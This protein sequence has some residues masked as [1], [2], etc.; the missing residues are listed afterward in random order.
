[1]FN[2]YLLF[3]K[4]CC[5]LSVALICSHCIVVMQW[6]FVLCNNFEVRWLLFCN[7][8]H[9]CVLIFIDNSD[10]QIWTAIC[11][12]SSHPFPLLTMA[13]STPVPAFFQSSDPPPQ[14]RLA[15]TFTELSYNFHPPTITAFKRLPSKVSWETSCHIHSPSSSSTSPQN[16][17]PPTPNRRSSQDTT[18]DDDNTSTRSSDSEDSKISKP[19]GEPGRPDSGGHNLEKALLKHGWTTKSFKKLKVSCNART[20]QF[21]SILPSWRHMYIIEWASIL[22]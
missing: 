19:N 1:M 8:F 15:N 2:G 6:F 10:Y 12:C 17:I 20:T 3:V 11:I 13:S 21:H 9:F 14:L 18:P 22:T 5:V 16:A 4:L 7:N